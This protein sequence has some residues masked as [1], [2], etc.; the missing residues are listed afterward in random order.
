MERRFLSVSSISR[1]GLVVAILLSWSCGSS[2]DAAPPIGRGTEPSTAVPAGAHEVG[3]SVVTKVLVVVEENHS[4]AQMREG[5]PVTF[6]LAK[7]Y[8]YATRF[9]AIAHPSLPDYLAVVAGRTFGVRDDSNPS[10]HQLTGSTVFGQ[11][12][13]SGISARLYA[14]AMPRPCAPIN[15][16]RYV[17]RHNPWAYFVDERTACRLNDV[18][19]KHFDGDV[20]DGTLPTVGMVIP[21]LDYD[22]HDGSLAEADAWFAAMMD[23]VF[24]GPDWQAGRLVVVLTA[25]EDDRDHENRVLT[26]VLHP[27]QEHHVVRQPLT[28]YSLTRL[29]G[30]VAGLPYLG[31][32]E[33]APSMAA[34]FGLPLSSSPRP[35]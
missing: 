17:V 29:F 33:Q 31:H 8:G 15:V 23:R 26:V 21:D 12:V 28:H 1:F 35:R 4:L 9:T 16:G 14:Q 19:F 25:D 24:A 5:M 18:A 30:E 10:A 32:A 6:A 2:A 11:A 22:A 20:L 27:S 7:E 34:A 3:A 13:D